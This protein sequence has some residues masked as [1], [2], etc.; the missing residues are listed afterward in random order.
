VNTT[1]FGLNLAVAVLLLV[2][3]LVT[4]KRGRQQ[5]HIRLAVVTVVALLAAIWQAERYGQGFTFVALELEVHMVFA[6]ATLLALPPVAFTGLR[7]RKADGWRRL[8]LRCVYLFVTCIVLA[9]L[10]ACYMFLHAVAKA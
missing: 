9:I 1:L 10:T 8:H 3:T 6:I 7:L 5:L 4:G 2:A